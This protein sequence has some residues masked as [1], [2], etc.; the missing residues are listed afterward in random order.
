MCRV[1]SPSLFLFII[2]VSL[3]AC[4]CP[5]LSAADEP[6]AT[7]FTPD[8]FKINKLLGRGVNLGN[9]LEGPNEGAWGVILQEEYF[10]LIKD[11][12]FN[13]IRLPVRWSA[14]AL[15]EPPYTIDPKFFGRVD[16]AVKNTL[17]RNLALVFTMHYYNE[18]YSDP[19]GHKERYLA[20]WKQIAEHY[21]D[22]P[23][24]L[25]FE[26]LN[27]PQ[28]SLDIAGWNVLLKEALAVVR[29][30]NPY[31]TVVIGPANFNDIYKIKT[32]ELPKD[33]RNIIVT[34]HY[35]LPYRFTHQ[36]APWVPD[37]NK[38]LGMKWTGSEDEKRLVVKDFDLAANWANQNNRPIH[39]GE[40]G[41]FEKADMDSR[42]RWTKCVADTAVEH[43]FS[44]S[45]WE[46]C[47]GFGLYDR[48]TKSWHKELLD[49]VIPPAAS[50]P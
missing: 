24:T 22:Y 31:R 29:R 11:A 27:E 20:L 36:G 35:Y 37:S 26:L 15:N 28:G 40:F 10:Q 33:D 16:W 32:L 39:L 1:K 18:L 41:A 49:T 23:E 5:R 48:R 21:K 13:S 6:N 47:S 19:N 25:L 38:W 7:K 45:Y 30:S 50:P 34:F 3:V 14:H 9:A 46:F 4:S 17:S 8:P 12:G 43:G 44:F 2:A 42:A